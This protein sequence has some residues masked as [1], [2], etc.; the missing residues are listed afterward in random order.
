[1]KSNLNMSAPA[2]V[3]LLAARDI[4]PKLFGAL[5]EVLPLNVTTLPA[6]V[7]GATSAAAALLQSTQAPLLESVPAVDR[8]VL[9]ATALDITL[10]HTVQVKFSDVE[11][12]PW[13]F[14]GRTLESEVSIAPCRLELEADEIVLA[15]CDGQ[16]VWT[17][18]LRQGRS[19]FRSAFPLLELAED[20]S[21]ALAFSDQAFVQ[22]LPLL[23]LLRHVGAGV[24]GEV[25][26]LRAAFMF[27]D[28]NLHWPTYGCIDYREVVER[29]RKNHYH[30]S[31]A[32]IPLDTWFT[33][34]TAA[35]IF[36]RH[37]DAISLLVH[38][39]NHSKN[40]LARQRQASDREALV[41]QALERIVGLERSTGLK[42]CR[43]MVPPHGGCS[44]DMLGALAGAG[45]EGACI[46]AGS[47]IA[48]NP[49]A[50]WISTL[51][52]HP[53]ETIQGCAVLPRAAFTGRARN[54]ALICA[55]LGR[56]IV[57][58]GHQDDLKHGIEL[59]DELAG[60]VNGL[61][62]VAWTNL[63]SLMRLSY[64]YRM[65]A[66]TCHLTPL[67]P[68]VDFDVPAS[69][70]RVVVAPA[71]GHRDGGSFLISSTAGSARVRAGESWPLAGGESQRIRLVRDTQP[72]PADP[73]R[74]PRTPASLILRRLLTEGRDR[75][76]PA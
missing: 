15:A 41:S 62:D 40:E 51:G 50:G 52:F 47:L 31:F 60:F 58:R 67:A 17:V 56:P 27:D 23:H 63:S 42:V 57:L 70:Q 1:M 25:P 71:P 28:P 75:F 13:P 32:T 53:A 36:R 22:N 24:M 43:V 3:H 9:P 19:V 34:R 29:A 66:D 8:L 74:T 12:V 21:F 55:Y 2:P 72:R 35:D 45:F 65:E 68:R 61:G 11:Q 18:A 10:R 48:H 38:G 5:E 26:P 6:G 59:L 46:S 69:A 49:R 30:V 33:H 14:R 76:L 39:N 44:A 37:P 7:V 73:P 16:P 54:A 4:A 64:R 20:G